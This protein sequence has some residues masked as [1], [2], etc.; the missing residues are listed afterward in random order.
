MKLTQNLVIGMNT[1]ATLRNRPGVTTAKV[2]AK[3]LDVSEFFLQQVLLKLKR[4][5]LLM[6]KS[7]P[8]GGYWVNTGLQKQIT[9]S[10]VATAVGTTFAPSEA[11]SSAVEELNRTIVEAFLN[12]SV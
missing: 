6:R 3:E 9:A 8:G 11:K 7:G 10:D 4:A 2:L 12:T 1:I 5:K